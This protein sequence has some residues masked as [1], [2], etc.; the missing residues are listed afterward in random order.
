[1]KDIENINKKM[2][3]TACLINLK[4]IQEYFETMNHKDINSAEEKKVIT[5][6][7]DA[8][9]NELDSIKEKMT[10]IRQI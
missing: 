9:D 5:E 3:V 8:I 10:F 4:T 7:L 6:F 1:M 2:H